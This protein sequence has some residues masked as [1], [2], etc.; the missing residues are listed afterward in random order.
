M[1]LRRLWQPRRCARLHWASQRLPAAL[2]LEVEHT[3]AAPEGALQQSRLLRRHHQLFATCQASRA[4]TGRLHPG[5]DLR[6]SQN[7][8][9][10]ERLF[11]L[12]FVVFTN[13]KK[14]ASLRTTQLIASKDAVCKGILCKVLARRAT[15]ELHK[16]EL[17]NGVVLLIFVFLSSALSSCVLCSP[18]F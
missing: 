5:L 4:L 18:Y 1:S 13:H 3:R 15:T 12:N 16:M 6:C 2:A 9:S 17:L 7:L 8:I 10:L 14:H 11:V